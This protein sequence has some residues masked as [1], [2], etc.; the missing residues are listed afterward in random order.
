LDNLDF[1]KNIYQNIDVVWNISNTKE[2]VLLL[3]S[4]IKEKK[5]INYDFLEFEKE[6]LFLNLYNEVEKLSNKIL[7]EEI[8][9]DKLRSII[10]VIY[11]KNWIKNSWKDIKNIVLIFE[12]LKEKWIKSSYIEYMLKDYLIKKNTIK[13]MLKFFKM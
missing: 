12:K 13:K 9:D 2:K 1:A 4:A 11:N 8:L 6:I 10:N 7:D 3:V 5:Y